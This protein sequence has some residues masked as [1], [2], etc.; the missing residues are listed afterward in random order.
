M[1]T[2]NLR[3]LALTHSGTAGMVE[4]DSLVMTCVVR[5][6]Q[7][8]G[9]VDLASEILPHA[10]VDHRAGYLA[11]QCH[12]D[13]WVTDVSFPDPFLV[14]DRPPLVYLPLG[15]LGC[16]A[17]VTRP[18]SHS[19]TPADL[20]VLTCQGDLDV[21]NLLYSA[22]PSPAV[23]AHPAPAQ[24]GDEHA[25]SGAVP[26]ETTRRLLGIPEQTTLFLYFG[27][28]RPEKGVQRLIRIFEDLLT[29]GEDVA[30][31][32]IGPI[33]PAVPHDIDSQG[34][35]LELL[36]EI[37]NLKGNRVVYFPS[38]KRS[39]LQSLLDAADVAVTLSTNRDENYGFSQLEASQAGLPVLAT[40]WGGSRDIVLDGS[41]GYL[42]DVST[43]GWGLHID[44]PMFKSRVRLLAADPGL[45]HRMGES[46]RRHTA[47]LTEE[48]NL[49]N[50]LKNHCSRWSVHGGVAA[51]GARL[52][53]FG[54]MVDRRVPH[55][56]RGSRSSVAAAIDET[57]FMF[58][59]G[60]ADILLG[61]ATAY[62]AIDISTC[63]VWPKESRVVAEPLYLDERESSVRWQD[64]VWARW[65]PVTVVQLDLLHALHDRAEGLS[66][67]EIEQLGSAETARSLIS[68]GLAYVSMMR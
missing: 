25:R 67:E 47:Q 56:K 28:V 60:E 26:R 5:A 48:S 45:R 8:C 36:E 10:G 54:Q 68:R 46:G 15:E 63:D 21:M 16:G 62:G 66:W 51:P 4:S 43:S 37:A 14:P 52:S 57:S 49:V 44:E 55:W 7:Q 64:P 18:V 6:L 11:R 50:A 3:F 29:D 17:R 38:L 20:W 12:Y 13:F 2:D 41:T 33:V 58:G 59:P 30:L 34:E 53:P 9:T 65:E 1:K 31:I 61:F 22:H 35:P 27:R 39:R 32:I 42:V 40:A 19:A 24:R 23:R